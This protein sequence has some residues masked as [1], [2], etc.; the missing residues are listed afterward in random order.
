M[1]EEDLEIVLRQLAGS[2]LGDAEVKS[3][4]AKASGAGVKEFGKD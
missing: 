1:S 4:I 3:I 2:S